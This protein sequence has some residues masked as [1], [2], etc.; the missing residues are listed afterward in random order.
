MPGEVFVRF[1]SVVPNRHGHRPGVFALLAGIRGKQVLTAGE[2]AW[3]AEYRARAY[4][5]YD[6]PPQE[7]FADHAHPDAVC[8]FRA[9]AAEDHI[10]LTR[11]CL[12][13]LDA[14]GI[15]WQEARTSHPGTV[16][17]EDEFQVL[18]DPLIYPTDWPFR[19]HPTPSE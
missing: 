14:H 8:W 1:E 5:L 11:E 10:A 3:W 19:D 15:A 13:V 12:D 2:V 18:A 9:E 16:V 17:Y 6:E 4:A 7:L